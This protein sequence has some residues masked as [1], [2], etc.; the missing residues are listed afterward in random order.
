MNPL[1]PNPLDITPEEFEIFVRRYL[2]Q[3]GAALKDF[4]TE[5]LEKLKGSDGDYVIDVTARFEALGANFLVLI[6]CKRY[7]SNPVEREQVQ[8]LS[9]KRLSIGAQKAMLFTTS[10]FRKGAI[11]FA[12]THGIA[13]VLV[14]ENELSYAVK[15]WLQRLKAELVQP[16]SE[17]LTDF[18]F[19]GRVLETEK[20]ILPKQAQIQV[21]KI[22]VLKERLDY[23]RVISARGYGVEE[24]EIENLKT[25]IV[26]EEKFL[27]GMRESEA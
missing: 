11:D 7:A 1:L 21:W 2:E 27:E 22:A 10:A 24:S 20:P 26:E 17:S 23:L 18:L 3:Q 5:H 15:S 25:E 6:E 19:E 14:R 9:Q 13:L 12:A 8:A 4:R 16:S